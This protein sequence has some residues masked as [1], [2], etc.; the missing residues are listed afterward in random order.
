MDLY[1]WCC[2]F[3]VLSGLICYHIGVEDGKQKQAKK[4][5]KKC[6]ECEK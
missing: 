4:Q 5:F 1:I 6:E 3:I 2:I